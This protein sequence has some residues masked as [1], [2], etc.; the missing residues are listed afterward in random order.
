LPHG[1]CISVLWLL[2]RKGGPSAAPGCCKPHKVQDMI[3][4]W[5]ITFLLPQSG[6]GRTKLEDAGAARKGK[7]E[8]K[9]CFSL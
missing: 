7:R 1:A 3:L 4:S 8:G 2:L 6:L 5:T 9:D